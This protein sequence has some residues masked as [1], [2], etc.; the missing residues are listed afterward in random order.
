MCLVN[1]PFGAISDKCQ[2]FQ[3]IQAI[4][5]GDKVVAAVA[6]AFVSQFG[7]KVTS[8]QMLSLIHI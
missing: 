8:S 1:C 5:R 4:K 7:D 2:I 6:P 3:L